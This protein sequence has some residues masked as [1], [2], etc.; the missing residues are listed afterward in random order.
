[1]GIP[2]HSSLYSISHQ[3]C[4]KCHEGELFEAS[5]YD[6]KKFQRMPQSC[7]NCKQPYFLEPMFYEGAQ[8]VS[9]AIQVA[10]FVTWFVAFN[11]LFDEFSLVGFILSITVTSLLL[12]PFNWRMSRVIW[13]HFFVRYDKEKAKKS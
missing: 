7:E 8:Y 13:I 1:M 4:P 11:V 3:K 12:I 9:Y 2:H 5:M 6:L 10:L